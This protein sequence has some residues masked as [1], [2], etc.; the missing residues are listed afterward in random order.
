MVMALR[1]VEKLKKL[2]ERIIRCDCT[3]SFFQSFLTTA[4][5]LKAPIADMLS[6]SRITFACMKWQHV[7]FG[8]DLRNEFDHNFAFR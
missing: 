5:F 1:I 3:N 4:I 6:I 8:V 2:V 7:V